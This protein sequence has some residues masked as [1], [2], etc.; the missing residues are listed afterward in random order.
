MKMTTQ[1][2]ALDKVYKRRDRYEIPDWQREEVWGKP[3]RQKLIDSILRGWRLPKFYF[4]KISASEY[5]VVDGQ[6]R[7]AAIYEFLADELELPASATALYGGTKYSE[8][9]EVYSDAFDDFEIDIDEI[10]DATDEDIKEFFQRLQE[11]FP[12]SSSEKLNAVHSKLRNFAKQLIKHNFFKSTVAFKDK[13]YAHFDVTAK[14]LAIEIDGL[15]AGFRYEDLKQT[16]E[17]NKN[18]SS[19][20]KIA[21]RVTQA[22]DFLE[23]ALPEASPMLR[24]RSQ[25]QS[26]ITLACRL[27]EQGIR[28]SEAASFGEFVERFSASLSKQVELGHEATDPD[29]IEFQKTVNANVR[30]GPKTRHT[31]LLRKL[32]EFDPQFAEYFDTLAIKLSGIDKEIK[33]LGPIIQELVTDINAAE[34]ATTGKDLFKATNKTAKAM[35]G[36]AKPA[37]SFEDYKNLI[38]NLYFLF[39]EGPG[40]KLDGKQPESFRDVNSLRTALQ[41]DVDHGSGSKV[42]KKNRDLGKVFKTYA[43]VASPSVAAPERFPIVHLKLLTKLETDL[44]GMKAAYA[45]TSATDATS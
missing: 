28:E 29:M 11:G 36:L 32:F 17:N 31:I 14:V 34:A 15:D 4:L 7:L 6:Q 33:R 3:K 43:G 45:A 5:E 38:E 41:H 25:T 30:S 1:K 44:R 8:L 2:R 23:K 21:K 42:K 39:W 24:S 19:T 16:F 20:S 9:D 22:L 18:F 35:T 26:V 13:R 12:L 40:S 27:V 37:V 10:E